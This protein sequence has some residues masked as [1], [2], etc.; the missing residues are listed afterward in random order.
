MDIDI[1]QHQQV[2]EIIF[3]GKKHQAY[4]SANEVEIFY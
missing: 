4:V 3:C 1:P 2:S